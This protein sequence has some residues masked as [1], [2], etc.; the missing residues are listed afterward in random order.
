[1]WDKVNVGFLFVPHMRFVSVAIPVVF[2]RRVRQFV[3]G[4][5]SRRP[6]TVA[7]YEVPLSVID[8]LKFAGLPAG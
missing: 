5:K 7:A 8:I 3:V 4:M 1:M 2:V 6:G